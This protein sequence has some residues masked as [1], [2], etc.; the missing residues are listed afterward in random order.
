MR[1]F[2][3]FLFGFFI[4]LLSNAQITFEK[5]YYINNLDQRIDGF[6]KNQDWKDNPSQFEF[7][8]TDN[9]APST[10]DLNYAREFGFENGAKYIRATVD[11]DRSNVAL[12]SL[13]NRRS[14][15]LIEETLFLKMLVQGDAELFSYEDGNM[16]RYFYSNSDRGIKQLI[17]KKY[18]YENQKI[19]TNTYYKQQLLNS[20]KCVSV[21]KENIKKLRYQSSPLERFFIAYNNCKNPDYT[22]NIVKESRE[23]FHLNIRPGVKNAHLDLERFSTIGLASRKIS[24]DEEWSF[25]LGLEAEFILPFHKD[26]WSIFIEPTYQ[27]YKSSIQVD[28]VKSSA[29]YKSIELP[30]GL[31][32]YFFLN[33]KSKL[34][35]N[36]AYVID[37]NLNSTINVEN[38][39]LLEVKTRINFA[40]GAGYK[41]ADRYSFEFRYDM[42]RDLLG[43]YI[44]FTSSYGGFS[45]I[46]GYSLF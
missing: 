31:R 30:L 46:F 18:L 26:K 3:L 22:N 42:D 12:N 15:E 4:S 40:L 33:N 29:D 21:S 8:T 6:I 35:L 11:I 23:F 1:I 10:V 45:F 34:F 13:S 28:A 7:K 37:F 17:Y 38:R 41:Y 5:G 9:S 32:H 14:P 36:A 39:I 20:F 43:E 25:R 44:N 19:R 24:F 16:K 2:L 27:Y